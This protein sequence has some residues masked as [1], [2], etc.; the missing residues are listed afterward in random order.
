MTR[1]VLKL[2]KIIV[3]AV[4]MGTAVSSIYEP[5]GVV[6]GG[7][8]GVGI[9]L[10]ESLGIPMWVTNVVLNIPLF[11]TAFIILGKKSLLRSL[12]GMAAFTVTVAFAPPIRVFGGEV[13]A[14]ALCGGVLMGIGVGL[15]IGENTTT[16]GVDLIATMVNYRYRRFKTVWI[17]FGVD[18]VIIGVGI[19]FFGLINAVYAVFSLFL[20]SY[21]SGKIIDGPGR[22]KAVLVISRKDDL[23]ADFLMK[24]MQRGVTGLLSMGMYSGREGYSLLCVIQGRELP[25]VRKKIHKIDNRAFIMISDVTEVLGEGFV[26]NLY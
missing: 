6:A 9:I 14:A 24:D 4:L 10:K 17:M 20:V 13:F 25:Y 26:E 15:I 22:A 12:M 18:A 21:V 11:T 7:L 5:A 1:K 2:C 23:I 8:S 16:G 3:G 19:A